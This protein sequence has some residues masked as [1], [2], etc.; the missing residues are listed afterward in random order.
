MQG[1]RLHRKA[2]KRVQ[3]N[4]IVHKHRIHTAA[5]RKQAHRMNVSKQ[6][7]QNAQE[8][9]VYDGHS[10]ANTKKIN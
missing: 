4:A 9:F 2:G 3:L 1:T 5:H 7:E 8:I 6:N 10:P